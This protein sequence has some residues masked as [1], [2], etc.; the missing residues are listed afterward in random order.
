MNE[1]KK[2]A[3]NTIIIFI[4][5]IVTSIVGIYASRVV[6]DALGAS[7]YGLYNVVGGIVTM[8]N[9]MNSAMLSTTYRYI[10]FELGKG[11][12]GNIRKV[13]NTCFQIHIFFAFLIVLLGLTVGEWYIDHYLNVSDGKLSDARYVFHISLF[14][15]SIATLL[16]PFQGLIVAFE[17]FSTNAIIDIISYI[18]RLT[19]IL[20]FVYSEGNRLRLYS[21]LQ[22]SYN[23]LSCCLY[24]IYCIRYFSEIIRW[25]IYND[26][27]LC[28]EMFSYAIWTLFGA[29][30]SYGKTQGS[31]IIVNFFFGT[32]VNASFA[33][34]NQVEAVILMFARSLSNAAV[35][36]ITK[37]FSGGNEERSLKLTSY[38]SKYTFILM[39]L[40]AFP[41]IL[42]MDFL[43]GIWLKEIPQ[44]AVLYCQLT[45]LGG[46]IGCLGE[47]IPALI[48][49]TGNIKIYQI[50]F[51]TFNLIGLPIAF[52]FY[53]LGF[54]AETILIIFCIIGIL[55][56][57]IRVFLLKIIYKFDI[58]LL[59]RVSYSRIFLI[60]IPLI[61]FFYFYKNQDYSSI[62]EHIL[63]FILSEFFLILVI[64]IL[65]VDKIERG[66]IQNF[67]KKRFSKV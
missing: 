50:I 53:K 29:F 52:I 13:F 47:G 44:D 30:A 64:L 11:D 8:L 58:N 65:G 18:F 41:V 42:E 28:R 33:V 56:A 23:M 48:N 16:V 1:N 59:V 57:F 22:L 26:W 19:I 43:L 35:P 31:A 32:I 66:I 7:D 10:A 21:I 61:I 36:Q 34:A 46:L 25:K 63:G 39:S 9:V 15:A 67:I 45:I 55:A 62:T 4:R 60:S 5:L 12:K 20:L 37:N 54:P 6:L 49:A 27:K 51:H 40:V 17:K 3:I 38:I 2:I 14:T 24:Y